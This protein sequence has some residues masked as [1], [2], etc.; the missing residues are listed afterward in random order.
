VSNM[1]PSRQSSKEPITS[2]SRRSGDYLYDVKCY[3]VT[4]PAKGNHFFAVVVN[5]ARLE[6]GEWVA[7]TPGF[8]KEYGETIA[9]A[10]AAMNTAVDAWVTNRARSD[11]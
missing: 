7:V 1:D 10:I 8:Q 11:R 5:M 3:Q 6:S 4:M 2:Y 9:E